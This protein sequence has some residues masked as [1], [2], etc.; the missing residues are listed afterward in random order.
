MIKRDIISLRQKL[1]Q[2]PSPDLCDTYINLLCEIGNLNSGNILD[3]LILNSIK[4]FRA[5]HSL[6]ALV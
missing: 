1:S 4:H 6:K 2:D 3:N 5:G